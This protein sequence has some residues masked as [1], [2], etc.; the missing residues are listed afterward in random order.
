MNPQSSFTLADY[1]N[2]A[3]IV[4]G[5]GGLVVAA[6]SALFAWYAYNW[7]KQS[8]K[9]EARRRLSDAL[10]QYNELVISNENIR[11]YEKAEHPSGDLSDE[12]MVRMYRHFLKRKPLRRYLWRR[13]GA[14]LLSFTPIIHFLGTLPIQLSMTANLSRSMCC[15]GAIPRSS[16]M[17]CKRFGRELTRKVH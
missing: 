2:V 6:V 1:A 13:S 17:I 16:G 5:I 4:G 9:V 11:K 14:I 15:H 8:A 7:L 3:Q 12:E 10:R